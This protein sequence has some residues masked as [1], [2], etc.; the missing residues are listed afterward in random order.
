MQDIVVEYMVQT[1][2]KAVASA[3]SRGGKPTTED[4]IFLVR[5]VRCMIFVAVMSHSIIQLYYKQRC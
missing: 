1:M 3:A 5:K 2:E 4:L